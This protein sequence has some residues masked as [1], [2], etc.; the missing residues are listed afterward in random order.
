MWDT[1]SKAVA[2][3]GVDPCLLAI[4]LIVAAFLYFMRYTYRHHERMEE[5]RIQHWANLMRPGDGNNGT[6]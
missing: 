1:A 3:L 5:M 4:V 2:A 6:N